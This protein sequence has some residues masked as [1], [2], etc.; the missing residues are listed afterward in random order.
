[1][2][3]CT[4]LTAAAWAL[5]VALRSSIVWLAVPVVWLVAR[6]RPLHRYGL[7]LAF[8]PPSFR[9]HLM[10]ASAM[11]ATYGLGTV[12]A[13]RLLEGQ[14]FR[15]ELPPDLVPL[16]LH[17]L[18]VVAL[19]EEVFFRGYLQTRLDEA[20]PPRWRVFG[21]TLGPAWILQSAAFAACHLA[22]GDWRRLGVFFFA[23]LAGWLRAR[24]GSVAAA[25]AYHAAGNVAHLILARGL[26][27]PALV[28]DASFL[29]RRG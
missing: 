11:L 16:C 18:L 21:A 15:L 12:V 4:V 29:A 2:L 19:P 3:E 6:G 17:Q 9:A 13:A 5:A 10:I 23:L 8:R 7:E 24:S 25:G 28:P 1:M 20:F 22:T 14:G 26:R 27:P